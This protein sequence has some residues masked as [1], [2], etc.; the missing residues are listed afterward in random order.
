MSTVRYREYLLGS[1]LG[2]LVPIPLAVIF[3]DSI[4]SG[5]LGDWLGAVF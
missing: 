4:A 5:A 3:F 1:A 2:L